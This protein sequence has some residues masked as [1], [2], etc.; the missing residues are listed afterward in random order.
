MYTKGVPTLYKSLTK[1]S[2]HR[3]PIYM[4]ILKYREFINIINILIKKILKWFVEQNPRIIFITKISNDNLKKI[5]IWFL[6]SESYLILDARLTIGFQY[7]QYALG[8]FHRYGALLHDYLT[9]LWDLCDH[10]RCRLDIAQIGSAA[11]HSHN[12]HLLALGWGFVLAR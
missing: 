10:A 7:A 12:K 5:D 6:S 2:A 3:R 9:R 11:L 1:W 4:W 8:C